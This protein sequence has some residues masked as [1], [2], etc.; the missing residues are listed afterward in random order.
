MEKNDNH[1]N[2]DVLVVGGGP[3]GSTISTL[4]ARK[5]FRVVMLEKARHPRFHIGESLLP[6]NM[7]ILQELGVFDA[8]AE[9]GVPKQGAD[10]AHYSDPPGVFTTYYF[11]E[12][13]G[14]RNPRA[15]EVK[16]GAF[17]KKLF[18]HAA[19]SGVDAREEV[20]VRAVSHSAEGRARIEAE[21]GSGAK[22]VFDARY[23]V[24]AS[25]RDTF[26][27]NKFKLK[28]N[29]ARH[30]S[31]AIYA[32]FSGIER[33]AG[34][35]AG[36]IG[37][38]WLKQGWGW[39]IPLAGDI[40]SVGCVCWP[41]YLKQRKGLGGPEFLLKTLRQAPSMWG[42]MQ[43]A[44]LASKVRVAGNYSYAATRMAG[45]GWIMI[46]DAYS[47]LDPVFSSGVYLAMSSARRAAR[48]VD[49]ALA[50]PA[51]EAALQ[52]RYARETRR[53]LKKFSWFIYR[54]TTPPMRRLFR[55]PRNVW[56]TRQAVT[57]MLAG[58]VYCNRSADRRLALFKLIYHLAALG[59]RIRGGDGRG[60]SPV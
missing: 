4:L 26:Y 10:F 41:E 53:G 21:T 45:K 15:F 39:M 17:D 27:A 56:Q 16:R 1:E 38:Y 48:V 29:N 19:A 58:D 42:R 5:G 35:D 9:I 18:E 13:L 44:E 25:G 50:D 22:L 36:N 52:K 59:R 51:R 60:R 40:T 8:V 43:H 54:F 6:M 55:A 2:C 31:A 24:D 28:R 57:S 14:C 12:A 34:Q 30:R 47:F 46:G 49:G 3:G 11:R 33:R 20:A 7:P 37:I 32:H 23:V